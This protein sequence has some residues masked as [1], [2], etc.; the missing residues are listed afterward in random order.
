MLGF[1][2]RVWTIQYMKGV[3]DVA[4]NVIYQIISSIQSIQLTIKKNVIVYQL[5]ILARL[6]RC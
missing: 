3:H 1:Q 4:L 5:Y 2:H 6:V